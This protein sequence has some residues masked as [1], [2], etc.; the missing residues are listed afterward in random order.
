MCLIGH[1]PFLFLLFQHFLY[2]DSTRLQR[3]DPR[4]A[5]LSLPKSCNHCHTGVLHSLLRTHDN[6]RACKNRLSNRIKPPK[7]PEFPFCLSSPSSSINRCSRAAV[8]VPRPL[9]RFPKRQHQLIC[10]RR[11]LMGAVTD[12]AND[13]CPGRGSALVRA[14]LV[15]YAQSRG[16]HRNTA[17]PGVGEPPL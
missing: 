17:V 8:E 2:L 6:W 5:V 13:V 14:R 4:P 1:L 9:S 3:A 16:Y 10:E 15:T 11:G 7:H 12:G